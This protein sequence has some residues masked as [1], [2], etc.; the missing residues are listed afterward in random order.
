MIAANAGAREQAE[1][2]KD[3]AG[4]H[5]NDFLQ[6]MERVRLLVKQ[7]QLEDSARLGL[8][9]YQEGFQYP[10]FI[11]FEDGA[12]A[13]VEHVLAFVRLGRSS[14]GFAQ[15]LVVNL[16]E[17]S[18]N[19]FDFDKVFYHEMTHVVLNDAIGGDAALK[20]PHWVQEGLAQYCSGEGDQR[21]AD[22]ARRF[23][24]SQ[25]YRLLFPLDGPVTGFGYPQ[26]YLA[27]QYLYDK[28]SSNAVQALVRNLIAGQDIKA[29]IEDAA[30]MPYDQFL[31]EVKEYSLKVYQD[32]ATPDFQAIN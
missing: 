2:S 14:K 19:P 8:L 5:Q 3:Y 12:P 15:Q 22:T 28:H 25:A 13:N 31:K 26:Y 20:V 17:A 10:L 9:Q 23:H 18:H 7:A 29:A 1:I 6:Q 30:G 32:K 24:K 4:E 21:V 11:K 27:I 16:T